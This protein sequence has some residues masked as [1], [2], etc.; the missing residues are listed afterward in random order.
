MNTVDI[1]GRGFVR[2]FRAKTW[3]SYKALQP[4]QC[5]YVNAM[6]FAILYLLFKYFDWELYK[7]FMGLA[8]LF[9]G[10]AM[11]ADLLGFYKAVSETLLGKLVLMLGVAMGTNVAIAIAAQIVNGLIGADPSKFTHTIAFTSVLVAVPLILVLLTMFL[12][13]GVGVLAFFVMFHFLPD[14][15]SRLM[16]FPWYKPRENV[17]Y[18]GITA[19]VQAI[20]LLAICTFAYQWLQGGQTGYGEFLENRTR[21]FLYSF[22][23]Y[24][25]A[26]CQLEAGER[27]AFLDGG[28]VLIGSEVADEISFA[29][30]ECKMAVDKL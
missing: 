7:G 17:Q 15:N 27:I 24:Q 12:F 30:R 18:R 3:E 20:S 11:T 29:I 16:M 21:W 4:N 8:I 2:Q 25:K 26:P 22:E 1:A 9:W 6:L 13:L 14:E 19:L 23:M 5:S 10:M 28:R